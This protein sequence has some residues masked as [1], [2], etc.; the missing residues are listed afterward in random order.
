[1]NSNDPQREGA[2]AGRKTRSTGSNSGQRPGSREDVLRAGHW[3][4]PG[5]VRDGRGADGLVPQAG[6]RRPELR[7]SDP[8]AGARKPQSRAAT[9]LK[10][11]GRTRSWSL[12]IGRHEVTSHLVRTAGHHVQSKV[13][14][15][16]RCLTRCSTPVPLSTGFHGAECCNSRRNL[17]PTPQSARRR[18][19]TGRWRSEGSWSSRRSLRQPQGRMPPGPRSQ[20]PPFASRSLIRAMLFSLPSLLLPIQP[21]ACS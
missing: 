15:T 18:Y 10:A 16:K 13:P 8:G 21:A 2:S 1:M 11:R 7:R 20:P 9:N 14:G 6:K 4:Q 19:A 17:R 5:R 12:L 3:D